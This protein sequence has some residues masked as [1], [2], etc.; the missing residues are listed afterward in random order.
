MIRLVT[1]LLATLFLAGCINDIPTYQENANAKWADVQ[2]QYQRRA[3]LIPNLVA[4]V[5][6]FAAQEKTVLTEVTS[7]RAGATQIRVDASTITDPAAFKQF[8]DAQNRLSVGIGRLLA[9]S[10]NYPQL[11]S[12]ENFMALQSQLEGTENRIAVARRDFNEA[13]RQY[14]TELKTI[15]GRWVAH[16]MYPDAKPMEMFTATTPG[17][18]NAP[19][20]SF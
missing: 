7:A 4:T 8:E 14:N 11:R 3:D 2:A 12:S 20:V 18:E 16:W 19:A 9:T 13:V 15:P 6:G 1:A 17:A 5:K 10:E